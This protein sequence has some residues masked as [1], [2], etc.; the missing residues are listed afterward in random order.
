M[1]KIYV[2]YIE[3]KNYWRVGKCV[4][5]TNL[6]ALSFAMYDFPT[7]IAFIGLPCPKKDPN[8]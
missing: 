3:L 7:H 4:M 6:H 2:P 1:L 5:R 8:D